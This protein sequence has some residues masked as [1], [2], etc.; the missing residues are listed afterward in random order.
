M[1]RQPQYSTSHPK[2]SDNTELL[3]WAIDLEAMNWNWPEG[4]VKEYFQQNSNKLQTI[5]DNLPTSNIK[6]E[7]HFFYHSPALLSDISL[8]K[9]KLRPI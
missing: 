7:H 3:Q 1:S 8:L 6:I 5:A 4:Y 2:E 9:V